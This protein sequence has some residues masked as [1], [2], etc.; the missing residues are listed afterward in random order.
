MQ[1]IHNPYA[2]P[3]TEVDDIIS[4]DSFQR[5]KLFSAAG[6]MGRIRLITYLLGGY[7]A[8]IIIFLISIAMILYMSVMTKLTNSTSNISGN[9]G[10][11]IIVIFFIICILILFLNILWCIQRSHDI[12][13][14]GWSVIFLVIPPLCL[15]WIFKKG[16]TRAN[17]FGPPP[18]PN[19]MGV[20]I[21]CGLFIIIGGV[22]LMNRYFLN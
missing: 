2:P 8:A 1:D 5:V 19:S 15:I 20:N 22:Y 16:D 14:P 3:K 13:W 11:I 4:G 6:R 10:Y 7:F 18:E 9:M 12:G 17:R 21:T